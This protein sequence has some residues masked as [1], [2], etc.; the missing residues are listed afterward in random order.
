MLEELRIQNF[1]IIDNLT[2]EFTNGF[3]VITGETGAG[4]SILVDAVELLLGSRTDYSYVRAGTD[5]AVVEG[6]FVLSEQAQAQI[7]PLLM[8]ADL[9]H[10]ESEA[11]YLT[12]SRELRAN[13]RSSSRLNGVTCSAE[14]LR[15]VGETLVDIHGQSAHM[16]LFKPRAH[17]NL[18]DRYADL[19]EVRSALSKVVDALHELRR[20]MRSLRDDKEAL[21]RRADRLRYEVEDIDSA[22]L[23]AG[24]E[25]SLM[26]ELGRLSNSE[27]LAE[28]AGESITLLS[29]NE[30]NDEIIPAVD[31]LM[32]VT[33]LLA[34]LVSLDPSLKDDYDLV[35]DISTNAQEL[36]INLSGYFDEIEHDPNRLAEVE[37]RMD[38]IKR[39]DCRFD[40]L[41]Q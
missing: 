30:G 5:K 37:E 17:M 1:A 24:E 9:I 18:L 31:A 41:R 26:I 29:G 12:L 40:C 33:Q 13:G 23:D 38:L 21:E 7:V 10:D 2:L 19:L 14:L 20:E 35:Q 39:Y 25:E 8:E 3:N 11:R 34:K 6:V 15:E 32:Q 22:K 28:L 16:S 36:A 4:K 27:K